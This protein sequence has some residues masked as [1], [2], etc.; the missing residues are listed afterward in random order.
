MPVFQGDRTFLT[1]TRT[2]IF[3]FKTE[4]ENKLSKRYKWK[5]N[6]MLSFF[7]FQLF[8]CL[9]FSHQFLFC[10]KSPVVRLVNMLRFGTNHLFTNLFVDFM[11]LLFI[12]VI[13]RLKKLCRYDLQTFW[14][15]SNA[16]RPNIM[17]RGTLT[18]FLYFKLS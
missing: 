4:Y 18:L 8:F 16:C 5:H 12:S 13:Y 15:L 9:S 11:L 1:Y 3:M 17:F 10:I 7:S 2:C 6:C 14:S